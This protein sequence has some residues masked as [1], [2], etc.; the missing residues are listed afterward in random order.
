MTA[1]SGKSTLVR[2]AAW[3]VGMRWSVRLLGLL[4]TVVMARILLPA[5]Y[6]VVAMASVVVGLIQAFLDF[7][8]STALLR[9]AE[10]DRDDIDS[11]WTLRVIQGCIVFAV[12]VLVS[13]L[14]VRYFGEPRVMYVLWTLGLC[15]AVTCMANIG[16]TLAQKAFNFSLD[17]KLQVI[18]KVL[19][20]IVTIVAGL[21]LRDYRALVMGIATGQISMTLLSY[22]MHPYR[23]RWNTSKIGEIWA[24]TKWL[25]L[26]S[27][28]SFV[29][30]RGDELV[31]GR[32][33]TD[34]AQFGVYSVGSDFGQMPTSEVGP[35]LLRALL[36]LL[37]SMTG[38]V[39]QINA[40]VIKAAG[41]A[42]TVTWALGLGFAA[43]AGPATVLVLG[44]NWSAAAPYVA[45]FAI[46]GAIQSM[47]GSLNTLLVMRGRT[48][49]HSMT[50][51]TEFVAF[52]AAALVLVPMLSIYGLVWA[53]ACGALC[54]AA[55]AMFFAWR[56]CE[57]RLRALAMAL[58]RPV[59]GAV[60][61]YLL[62]RWAM[63]HVQ[64]PAVQLAI[65][66][67]MGGVFYVAWCAVSWRLLGCPDGL[68]S[69][70][71]GYLRRRLSRPRTA[72]H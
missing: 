3:A 21:M 62:V 60:L 20:V 70:V 34:S 31:A 59:I 2:G 43:V 27:I 14:A 16:V 39:Q 51:W 71:L 36:P 45:G 29:M 61:M 56:Y 72:T 25:M 24:V 44:P 7:G 64:A 13:P 68:E 52:L 17:F 69:M 67:L 26:S 28:G 58:I 1:A 53:R 54:G 33:A 47:P 40:A 38:S 35:A 46:V 57:L 9:K 8:A 41:A 11:A 5:E 6:G 32:V 18:S 65:G 4:N 55:A 63:G 23:P 66:I 19:G 12:L 48:K 37:S 15:M 22:W 10:V 49:Q 30:R 42:N 50:V